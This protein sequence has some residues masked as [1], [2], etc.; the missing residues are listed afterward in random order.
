MLE[1]TQR[2]GK[3][4]VYIHLSSKQYKVNRE[5]VSKVHSYSKAIHPPLPH[6][7]RIGS[8]KAQAHQSRTISEAEETF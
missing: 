6:Y 2:M 8:G 7:H 4:Y 3:F 1:N 5:D